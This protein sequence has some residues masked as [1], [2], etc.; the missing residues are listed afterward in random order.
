M[1]YLA[2]V[3]DRK[4]ADLKK[5]LP[6]EGKL[7]ASAILRNDYAGFRTSLDLGEER[8][9]IVPEIAA[10]RPTLPAQP[11]CGDI[12]KQ[13]AMFAQGGAQAVSVVTE[14]AL[15]GGAW[16]MVSAVSRVSAVPVLAR[17][18]YIHPAQVCQAIVSGADA[19]NLLL[20]AI[21]AKELEPLYR[22]A[23]GLGI[24]VMLEVHT[25]AELDA[26]MDLEAELI[27]I[28]NADPHTLQ[29]DLSVTEN[30][31]EELPASVTVLAAGGINSAQAAQRM[32]DAG[33]NGVLLQEELDPLD[34]PQD[35]MAEI[36][37]LSPGAGE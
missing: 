31:I 35:F 17:D 21:P 32:L 11:P 3:L 27:C 14:P 10:I 29:A 18:V 36:S 13:Y 7:R 19:I 12:L 37:A 24:D 20:A 22:M 30:L 15:Y 28:N 4:R 8:L 9:S 34:I 1:D 5:I 6:L 25:L 33:V 23:T 2:T 16:N 26:A